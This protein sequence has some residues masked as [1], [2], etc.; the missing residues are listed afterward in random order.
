MELSCDNWE[1]QGVVGTTLHVSHT[2]AFVVS[3]KNQINMP[4]GGME[5]P[6]SFQCTPGQYRVNWTKKDA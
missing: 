6:S 4:S 2:S 5:I 1:A 3:L